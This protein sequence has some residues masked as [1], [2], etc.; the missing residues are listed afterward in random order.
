MK[1][2]HFKYNIHEFKHVISLILSRLKILNPDSGRTK[3]LVITFYGYK[4][5]QKISE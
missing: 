3:D 5:K 2:K 4:S 1:S